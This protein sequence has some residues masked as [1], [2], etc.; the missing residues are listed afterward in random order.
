MD[1]S[2]PLT[3]PDILRALAKPGPKKIRFRKYEGTAA[4]AADAMANQNTNIEV[5]NNDEVEFQEGDEVIDITTKEQGVVGSR[6]QKPSVRRKMVASD[7]ILGATV[8][9]SGHVAS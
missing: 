5:G 3:R 8:G 9:S 7:V 6:T 1:N 4:A 2:E